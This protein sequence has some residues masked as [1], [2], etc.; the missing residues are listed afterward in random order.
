MGKTNQKQLIITSV[1]WSFAEKLSSQLV[2]F[3]V[4]VVLARILLPDDYGLVS[5]IMVFVTLAE[6]FVNS[7]F[8]AA[9]IQNKE[10]EEIDFSTIFYMSLACSILI[11]AVVF[12][13]AYPIADFYGRGELSLL[14][15]VFAIKIIIG[16]FNSI[17]RAYVARNM[18]FRKLFYSTLIGTVLSG[19]IGII[20]A[21]LGYGAWSLVAQSISITLIDIIVLLVVVPWRPKLLFSLERGKKMMSF[22]WKILF[23]DFSGTFF[24][25]LR[26]LIIG[27][28]YSSSDLA[29]YDKGNQIP[30]LVA[31]NIGNAVSS[32]IFPAMS[33]ESDNLSAV[34]SFCSRSMKTMSYIISPLMFGIAACAPALI[35]FL[36][37]DK[38]SACI[39]YV[40]ILAFGYALGTIGMV[41]IQALKAIGESGTVLKLEFI[42]KPV[43]LAL[44]LIG[45][46]QSVW[47]I[48]LSML[49]YELFGFAVNAVQLRKYLKYS[50]LEQLRDVLPHVALSAVMFII[51]SPIY[52][53]NNL[54]LTLI[55]QISVGFLIYIGG[56]LLFKFDTLQFIFKLA[57][58]KGDIC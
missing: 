37:T 56:S 51:V 28:A 38:W 54:L 44:L 31:N 6:V 15:Q 7:G 14:L 12:L 30:Q 55:I 40:Q 17:Q 22:G 3:F 20:M 13:L 26:S 45:V 47:G 58:Q 2:A 35:V 36:Y 8:S 24:S 25:Q 52:I 34:K 41:P 21:V 33:D 39:P 57:R 9:L 1:L 29:F 10:A 46:S 48:A 23:A 19:F 18:L 27:K 16:S 42:K 53:E 5:M 43:F 50:L 11:Y 32:V 49:C 4:S